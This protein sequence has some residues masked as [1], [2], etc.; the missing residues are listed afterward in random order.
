MMYCDYDESQEER[1]LEQDNE[2]DELEALQ[3]L[4]SLPR[5][6][7]SHDEQEPEP[8]KWDDYDDETSGEEWINPFSRESGGE[9]T[10]TVLAAM[11]YPLLKNLD[12]KMTKIESAFSTLS[13]GTSI[14]HEPIM[15]PPMYP[16][17]SSRGNQMNVPEIRSRI[18]NFKG[19]F[20]KQNNERFNLPSAQTG[21]GA[22]L[23]L[24][25][26]IGQYSD[27]ISR[28][29]SITLNLVNEKNWAD[30]RSK[31]IYIENLLGEI[32]K[33]TWIQW[34]MAYLR[35]YEELVN[36]VDDPQNVISQIRRIILL[37]DPYQGSTV[38][39]DQA[40]NDLERLTCNSMKDLFDYVNDFKVL[41]ARSGRMYTSPELSEKFFRKMP[42]L[43][44]RELEK[45]YFE[46]YNGNTVGVL[47]RI[48]FSYQYLAEQCKKAAL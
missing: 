48:N 14:P 31:V 26:D 13:T 34:R 7:Q 43:L 37:D 11:E 12:S 32:E 16:L 45:A 18:S 42:P 9:Q 30:N 29:E 46:K 2:D 17:G 19:G 10:E 41:A 33:K 28:W 25:E 22:M 3:I 6:K 40:Y 20:A 27:V 35:E 8:P 38:E 21:Q 4:A 36:I 44:G 15:G 24:P 5:E 23:V 47:P 39:Q 1:K